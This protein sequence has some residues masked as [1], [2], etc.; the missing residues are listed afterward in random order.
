MS[1]DTDLSCGVERVIGRMTFERDVEG[2]IASLPVDGFDIPYALPLA[3]AVHQTVLSAH[4]GDG[5]GATDGLVD[6]R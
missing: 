6:P 2:R 1:V 3:N 5:V 4:G